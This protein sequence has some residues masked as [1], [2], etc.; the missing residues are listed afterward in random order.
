[1]CSNLFDRRFKALQQ[2][3]DIFL[4]RVMS[5]V[6][7]IMNFLEVVYKQLR[8]QLGKLLA[9]IWLKCFECH[10]NRQQLKMC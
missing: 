10:K 9:N 5:V 3:H 6:N 8:L 1:M 7:L 4:P 2:S